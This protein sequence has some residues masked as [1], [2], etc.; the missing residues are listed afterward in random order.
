MRRDVRDFSAKRFLTGKRTMKAQPTL[1]ICSQPFCFLSRQ[2]IIGSIVLSMS[3]SLVLTS[4][5]YAQPAQY[6]KNTQ[7]NRLEVEG[8]LKAWQ[9]NMMQIVSQEGKVA[10]F[11]IPD[12]PGAVRFKAKLKFEAVT[13]GM[14]VRVEAPAT[15]GQFLE[16]FKSIEVFLPDP[17]KMSGK[18]SPL[19]RSWNIPGIYPM[20]MITMQTPG[21]MPSPNVRVV[22]AVIGVNANKLLLQCGSKQTTLDLSESVSVDFLGNTLQYAKPGDHVRTSGQ[23]NPSTGQFMANSVEVTAAKPIGNDAPPQPTMPLESMKLRVKEKSKA[24]SKNEGPVMVPENPEA[25]PT[26]AIEPGIPKPE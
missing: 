20:S 23:L 16:P 26:P 22:G 1:I 17:S 10:A 25:T 11:P 8:T 5:S 14:M 21:S 3:A 7:G 13:R 19:D 6:G 4:H 18:S 2:A 15:G 9:G 24:K 12:R